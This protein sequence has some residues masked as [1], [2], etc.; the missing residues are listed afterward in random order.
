MKK[1]NT[2]KRT[3]QQTSLAAFVQESPKQSLKKEGDTTV[4]TKL[5]PKS[6]FQN[7]GLFLSGLYPNSSCLNHTSKNKIKIASFDMDWTLIRTKGGQTF[8]K[9]KDDWLL[10]FDEKTQ[11]KLVE[12]D[13]EDYKIVVFTNQAGVAAGKTKVPDLNHKFGAIQQ[14]VGVPMIFM[15]SIT[16]ESIF[17]KPQTGM[18][19]Y[20]VDNLLK[21]ESKNID[22][23]NSFYCGDAAGRT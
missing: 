9:N 17:R 15:A 1:P 10:L 20:L 11:D 5:E 7:H 12:L 8:P 13:K 21:S 16:K 23:E 6:Q 14:K 4:S 22:M 18:W 2:L 3:L 19:K